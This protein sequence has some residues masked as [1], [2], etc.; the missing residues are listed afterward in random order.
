MATVI[1]LEDFQPSKRSMVVS[2]IA[3]DALYNA[4][5]IMPQQPW[6]E[7]LESNFY[8]R[9][10]GFDLKLRDQLMVSSSA[11]IDLVLRTAGAVLVGATS[12]P[13]GYHPL[14]LWDTLEEGEF[15]K[16]LANARDTKRFFDDPPR[17]VTIAEAPSRNVASFR[18]EHGTCVDL[19]FQSPF[20]P[21]NPRHRRRHLRHRRN[22]IAHA[23]YWR[24]NKG[25]RPTI[26]A[27]H[28]FGAD[29]YWLNEWLFALK[30]FYGKGC[31]VLLF[32]L[33]FHGQRQSRFS[34]F[35]GYGFFA[36]GLSGVNEAV[37]QAVFDLRIF[38]NY[39]E[40]AYGVSLMGITGISLGGFTSAVMATVEP[41]LKF[42]IP[43]VP[44]VSVADLVLE[45]FPL[46]PLLRSMMVATGKTI[47]DIRHMLA[48]STPLTYDPVVPRERLM[49][50]GG[51][52][53]RLA[54]P[55]HS[56]LLWDHWQRCRI[57]WFP[58]SH[59]LHLD[60][61]DYLKQTARFIGQFGFLNKTR[62]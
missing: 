61:G 10:E 47:K 7:N 31:D 8:R 45:W 1:T 58:G 13:A 26:I 3:H 53:D 62:R 43:N 52:G 46:G 28:G 19:C 40:D 32:T 5:S 51:V 41:R 21:V 55:K 42:V 30:W 29:Q 56:R 59:V 48:V 12:I 9:P 24:H 44:V 14:R 50:I 35:S 17:K 39:L 22:Q 36:G 18:P 4:P 23:R 25:P 6:W 27:V 49:I 60:R 57:H 2:R 16:S 54:P 15:Y 38:M 11:A 34:P 33:P 37:A 20:E